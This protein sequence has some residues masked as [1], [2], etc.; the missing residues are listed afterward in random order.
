MQHEL[1]SS[2]REV[3]D[4]SLKN[5]NLDKER[6]ARVIGVKEIGMRLAASESNFYYLLFP[7]QS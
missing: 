7:G 5:A 4:L 1:E 2:Q 6:A 3:F